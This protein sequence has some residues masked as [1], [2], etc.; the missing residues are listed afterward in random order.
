MD[1]ITYEEGFE[2]LKNII[3][4]LEQGS[5][6]VD[7]LGEKVKRAAL[8]IELCKN[9]LTATEDEVNKVIASMENPDLKNL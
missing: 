2:E 4:H 3:S 5:I 9:K 8:L 6:A 7:E 1:K